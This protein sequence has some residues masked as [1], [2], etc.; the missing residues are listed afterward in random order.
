MI[1]LCVEE[2]FRQVTLPELLQHA[3]VEEDDFEAEFSDLEDCFAQIYELQRNEF[4]ACVAGAFYSREVWRE[5]MRAAAHAMLEFL[6]EDRRRARFMSVEVHAAGERARLIR[7][8]AMQGF[9]VLIDQGR[10]EMEDPEMLTL[11]TAEAI[12]SAI[13]QQF[14]TAIAADDFERLERMIPEM[15]YL[16]ILPYL[17]E[18]VAREE[19]AVPVPPPE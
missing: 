8:E 7:D 19:L 16:A 12:G 10:Q 3:G 9:F 4:V 17:G 2:G 5:Q 14:Q 6:R 1:D 13:Y 18:D 15:T 11:H